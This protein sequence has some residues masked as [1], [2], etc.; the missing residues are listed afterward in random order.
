MHVLFGLCVARTIK[1]LFLSFIWNE[2]FVLWDFKLYQSSYEKDTG[3]VF[4]NNKLLEL[5][6]E[7]LYY[8]LFV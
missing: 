5:L 4:N 1:V 8:V 2:S 3:I 7:P 6:N